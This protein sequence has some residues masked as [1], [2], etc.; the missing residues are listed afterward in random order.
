MKTLI[1]N[2]YLIILPFL[3]TAC[4]ITSPNNISDKK[5]LEIYNKVINEIKNY[6]K[7]G[8][9]YL[10]KKY[11]HKA[12]LAY[13]KVN[14]YEAKE[15]YSKKYI[16]SL[17]NRAKF[18]A[19]Y[20]FKKAKAYEKKNKLKSLY[21]IN[22]TMRNDPFLPEAIA[23]KEILLKDKKVKRFINKK[24]KE[25][26]KLLQ[27][28]KINVY[29]TLA[30]NN[31]VKKLHKY[32][33]NNPFVLQAKNEIKNSY[34]NLIKNSIKLYNKKQYNEAKKEF[35]VLNSIYQDDDKIDSYLY[36]IKQK[37]L[38]EEAKDY[39]AKKDYTKAQEMAKNILKSDKNNKEAKE[40]LKASILAKCDIT[41]KLE[42]KGIKLYL[43]QNFDDAKKIFEKIIGCEPD[44]QIAYAYLKKINQQLNTIKKL[45]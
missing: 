34:E 44:N 21:Y 9:I 33:E 17:K 41:G 7:E 43:N 20:F 39:L 32:D 18:N 24:E 12:I 26:Q 22:I 28:N 10:K 6:K 31:A 5:K 23:L 2:F 15:V 11:Y 30:L 27:K 35:S 38:I 16:N 45:R 4:S 29:H 1:K 37:E 3:F 40:I 8:D 36:S 19:N 13:E 42:S 14:F 25:V